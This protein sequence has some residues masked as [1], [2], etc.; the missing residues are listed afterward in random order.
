MLVLL[1]TRAAVMGTLT[2]TP[3]EACSCAR[4]QGLEIQ[5]QDLTVSQSRMEVELKAQQDQLR[6]LIARLPRDVNGEPTTTMSGAALDIDPTTT[7]GVSASGATAQAA[8]GAGGAMGGDRR[9]LSSSGAGTSVATRSWQTHVFPDGHSCPS[10]ADGRSKTLL[11]VTNDSAV[12]WDPHPANLPFAANLSLVSVGKKWQTSEVQSFPSPL[13][14]VHDVRRSHSPPPIQGN[15]RALLLT[16]ARSNGRRAAPVSP[17]SSCRS[18][19]AS[20]SWM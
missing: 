13:N 12:T 17:P 20:R 18:P 5:V 4:V 14:I 1:A 9:R 10:M 19:P 7:V 6:V 16:D 2:G 15:H 8:S 11:P 3:S